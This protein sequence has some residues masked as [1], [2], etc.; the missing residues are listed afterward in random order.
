[1]I[2]CRGYA[3]TAI[4]IKVITFKERGKRE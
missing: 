1:L 2:I 4:I 3:V